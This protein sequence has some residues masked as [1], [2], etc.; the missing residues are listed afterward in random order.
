MNWG[1]FVESVNFHFFVFMP[2]IVE[3][4]QWTLG[5]VKESHEVLEPKKKKKNSNYQ[6]Y[7]PNIAHFHISLLNKYSHL[8]YALLMHKPTNYIISAF[9]PHRSLL[10]R[11]NQQTVLGAHCVLRTLEKTKMTKTSHLASIYTY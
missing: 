3:N 1:A 8:Q 4:K 5:K 2:K 9:M 10:L 11:V 6:F 7:L